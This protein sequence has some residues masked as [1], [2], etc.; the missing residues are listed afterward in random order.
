MRCHGLRNTVIVGHSSAEIPLMCILPFTYFLY[1]LGF[2]C[3]MIT[4][5]IHPAVMLSCHVP[6]MCS[7][8]LCL[9]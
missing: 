4:S 5:S 6:L 9:L 3:E 1:Y 8:D 2:P 7:V